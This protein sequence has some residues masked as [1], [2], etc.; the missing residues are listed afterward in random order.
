MVVFVPP[1]DTAD[2]TRSPAFYDATFDYL[3]A[4]GISELDDEPT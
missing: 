3:K 4:L 2:P 1:G